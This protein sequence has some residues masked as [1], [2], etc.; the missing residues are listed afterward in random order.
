MLSGHPV[1][2]DVTQLV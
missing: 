2:R 1:K